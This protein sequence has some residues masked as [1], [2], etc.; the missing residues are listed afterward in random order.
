MDVLVVLAQDY[1][2]RPL[3]ER[4]GYIAGVVVVLL[5]LVWAAVAIARKIRGR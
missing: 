3:G 2:S 1:G 4:I 5:L